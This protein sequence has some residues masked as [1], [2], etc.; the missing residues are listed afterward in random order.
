MTQT[1][2][3]DSAEP[4]A[5]LPYRDAPAGAAVASEAALEALRKTRP[6][7]MLF[8]IPLFLYAAVGGTVGIG[9]VVI[10]AS[11]LVTGPAP[12]PPYIN[13]AS[14]NLLFAPIALVGG[15]LAVRYFRAAGRAYWRRDGDDVERALVA[16]KRLWLWVGVTIIVLILFPV[17]MVVAA[18]LTHEWP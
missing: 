3:L 12:T 2:H 16:L 6:W 5:T 4:A 14:I 15:V 8:A 9:W 17:S 11:R 10:L 7:A 13:F 1:Q 18:V